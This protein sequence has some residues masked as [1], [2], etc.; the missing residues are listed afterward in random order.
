M[1][2]KLSK[3]FLYVALFSVV[4][5]MTSTFFPFIGGKDYFFRTAVELSS[6]FFVLWWAFQARPGVV[7]NLLKQVASQPLFIAVSLF[8]FVF[9]L[10]R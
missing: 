5:V 3:A 2:L 6:I 9:L 8:V 4:I 1:L 10:D 7:R